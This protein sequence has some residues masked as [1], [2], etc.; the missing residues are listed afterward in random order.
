MMAPLKLYASSEEPA[1]TYWPGN[2]RVKA[3]LS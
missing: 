1:G 3:D 2:S